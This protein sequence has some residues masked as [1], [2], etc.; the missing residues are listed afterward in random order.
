MP[1]CK[2][3]LRESGYTL[4][5]VW[6]QNAVVPEEASRCVHDMIAETARREPE[7]M[8]VCAWDGLLTHSKLDELSTRLAAH[9]A[10][11][12]VEP[13]VIVPLCFEKSMWT[14]V[15]ML[16]VM[17]AGGASM[18]MDSTQP[19]ERLQTIV[20]Q[21]TP[22]VM[23]SSAA[24]EE[25]VGRLVDCPLII[26]DSG[27]LTHLQQLEASYTSET[28]GLPKVR[29]TD[30]LYVVFTSGSTGQPKGAVTTHANFSSA[31]QHQRE[32]LGIS[33]T[34]RVYDFASYAFDGV[35]F[36]LLHT[37]RAGGCLCVPRQEGMWNNLARSMREMKVNFSHLTPTASR[38]LAK[39]DVPSLETLLMAGE[40]M[41]KNDARSWAQFVNLINLYGPAECT[42][43]STAAHIRAHDGDGGQPEPEPSIGKGVGVNTWV[44]DATDPEQ[45]A[46]PGCI[47]E[48]VLEGP[49]IG[50]GYLRD[51]IRTATAFIENPAWLLHGFPATE[52]SP[53]APG[54]CGRLYRTGDLVRYNTDGTLQFVGRKDEQVKLRGQRIELGEVEYHVQKHLLTTASVHLQ[55]VAEVIIPSGS[56]NPR[57]VVFV[58]EVNVH[59]DKSTCKSNT[60]ALGGHMQAVAIQPATGLDQKLAEAVP[61]YMVP[62][63]Y[64]A[65]KQIPMTVSG[66]TDR[67]KLREIG[68]SLTME[69]LVP[70]IGPTSRGKRRCPET[71]PERWLQNLWASVLGI[72]AHSISTQDSFL[73]VGGDSIGA[74]RLVDAAQRQG[75]SLSIADVFQTPRLCELA[76]CLSHVLRA[77]HDPV[78]FS[79]L[80]GSVT[81]ISLLEEL[82][83]A[84]SLKSKEGIIDVLPATAL[85]ISCLETF[86]GQCY[87]FYLDFPLQINVQ[88]IINICTRLWGA[89]DI[90][91]T[92]F[93]RSRG[94][95]FQVVL[96]NQESPP[97]DVFMTND[98]EKFSDEIFKR[99]PGNIS[100]LGSFIT[101]FTVVRGA[102]GHT[103]LI[104]R[105]SHAQYDGISLTY[106]MRLFTSLYSN[107]DEIP[108]APSFASYVQYANLQQSSGR[109]YWRSTLK[110]VP[111]TMIAGP[112][113]TNTALQMMYTVA[114]TVQAPRSLTGITPASVFITVCGH[115]LAEIARCKDVVFGLVVSGRSA[116]PTTK[117]DIIGPCFNVIP[118][119]YC[120]E[121]SMTFEQSC[122]L[123]QNQR[124]K[125]LRFETSSLRDIVTNC[126]DWPKDTDE[127]DWNVQFQDIDESPVA[128]FSGNVASL[129]TYKRCELSQQRGIDWF[130]RPV[131]S[132]WEISATANPAYHTPGKITDILDKILATI[133]RV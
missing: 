94:S 24:N 83:R 19:E 119:R 14:A 76:T 3:D 10:R 15:A 130:A 56:E 104:I 108:V 51:P 67:R 120:I 52:D 54:R 59:K 8:A 99:N 92:I 35:W 5:D 49:L 118:M 113:G 75:L 1:G 50:A 62:S 34:S 96:A 26:V 124:I 17:K 41:T 64:I 73:Q 114:K 20:K 132:L 45:L 65:V 43:T 7:A 84:L 101:R 116:L 74:M 22:T 61:R 12:G 44:V 30:M 16:A 66:K 4:R 110:G 71:E 23:V 129:S 42:V 88:K 11:V 112:A 111:L 39:S 105:M 117:R 97:L 69:Q 85:Q 106:L 29:P 13:G 102:R 133:I 131:G 115:V 121:R 57:L 72:D 37:L 82:A 21:V 36:N 122:T 58:A 78:P 86:G 95:Y 79:L 80:S 90:L 18:V 128:Y 127:F 98:M 100:L 103:R 125:G 46:A 109:D 70:P 89:I 68:S 81:V 6:S 126:T 107:N 93:C 31:L 32:L 77:C 48:L 27:Q 87:H 28:N 47:G 9:L 38:L 60:N 55:V 25:L 53:G 2:N 91:R 40:P 123:L 33:A 63:A